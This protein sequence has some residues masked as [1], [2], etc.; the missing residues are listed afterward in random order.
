MTLDIMLPD[1]D[2]ISFLRELRA[3]VETRE[4]PI[5]IIS[6]K[7]DITRREL[8]GNTMDVVDWLN[9]PIDRDRLVMAVGQAVSSATLPNILHVEDDED[10]TLVVSTLLAGRAN[11]VS[12]RNID[13]ATT[14]LG[15]QKFDLILLDVGLPGKSGLEFLDD[16]LERNAVIPVIIFSAHDVDKEVIGKV[17][18]YLVKSS[19]SNKKLVDT[20]TSVLQK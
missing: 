7:A 17:N 11:V 3:E 10:V 8:N 20:I 15:T 12:A 16:L 2:G 4:L 14:I 5:V 1:V 19:T 18:G 13:E 9:K 6:E